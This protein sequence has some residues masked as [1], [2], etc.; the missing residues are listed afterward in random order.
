[1]F[2][3]QNPMGSWFQTMGSGGGSNLSRFM[4]ETANE[5]ARRFDAEHKQKKQA[6]DQ[7]YQIALRGV[8]ND[9]EKMRLDQEYRNQQIGLQ[10]EQLAWE[11]DRFGQE[12]QQKAEQFAAQLGLSRDQFE[13]GKRQFDAGQQQRESEFGRNLEQRESEFGREFGQRGYEFDAGRDDRRYEFDLGRGDQRYEFDTGQ[14]NNERDFG[15]RQFE[16]DTGREDQ[17]YEFDTN[18]GLKRA[19]LGYNLLDTQARLQQNPEDYWYAADLARGAAEMP[20]TATFLSALRGNTTLPGYGQQGGLAPVGS[21][22]GVEQ[23]L[24]YSP[25]PALPQGAVDL[26]ALHPGIANNL[27]QQQGGRQGYWTQEPSGQ[28]AFRDAQQMAAVGPAVGFREGPGSGGDGQQMRITD[29]GF[30][31]NAAQAKVRQMAPGA[32]LPMVSPIQQARQQRDER[33]LAAIRGVAQDGAHKLGNGALENMSDTEYKLFSSG[34]G[35]VGADKNSFLSQ[36]RQSRIMN[37]PGM[38]RTA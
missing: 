7:N 26:D 3:P 16:Y 22:Q 6:L 19:E 9:E 18:T 25:A 14:G 13:E 33:N 5:D 36:Y 4:E 30:N 38:A 29:P 27:R 32:A 12:F 21:L 1:M 11:R 34:L 24:G 20:E 23:R 8:K 35:R 2:N 37:R 31:P 10:R 17:R 28:Y 15:Q